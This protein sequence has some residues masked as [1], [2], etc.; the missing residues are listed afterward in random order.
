VKKQKERLPDIERALA[1]WAKKETRSGRDVTDTEIYDRARRFAHGVAGAEFPDQTLSASWL[2]KFKQRNGIGH[3]RLQ[4]RA[5]ETNI[6]DSAKMIRGSPTLA[7]SQPSSA[8][9]PSS[10]AAGRSPL[11]GARSDDE[12][13]DSV[14]DFYNFPSS[15]FKQAQNRS[16]TSLNSAFTDTGHSSFSGSA[17]SPTASLTFSPDSNVGGF[18]PPGPHLPG[19]EGSGFQRPR[20]QTFPTLDL[21]YMNQTGAAPAEPDT[22]K[23]TSTAPSSALESPD[24]DLNA[25][26]FS[27]DSALASQRLRRPSSHANLVSASSSGSRS[28]S[29]TLEEARRGLDTA[30]SYIQRSGSRYEEN[31]LI[32]VM[33]FFEKTGLRQYTQHIKTPSSS[34]PP[35]G[36]LSQIPESGEVEMTNAPPGPI[37]AGTMT[38]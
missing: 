15:S 1:I 32:T 14:N 7:P 28:N 31:D 21:E 16:T 9:S 8:I 12:A 37:K 36:G 11:S 34:L 25:P 17:V 2:E 30:L 22:P 19:G 18:L 38:A 23:Y 29:P 13:K 4:R 6:P 3:G 33:R 35:L 27:L 10:P 5:S 24:H 20:S 26:H